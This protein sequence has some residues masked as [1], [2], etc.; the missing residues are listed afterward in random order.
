MWKTVKLGDV[1]EIQ[2]KKAQVKK[3]LADTDTVSFMPMEDLGIDEMYPAANQTKTLAKAYSSYT[4]FE[5]NDVLLAKITPCFENG[6]LGIVS[7]LKNGVG[8]GSSEYIVLRCGEEVLSQYIYYRLS[9]PS[10]RANGKEQMSGAVGHKRLPKDFVENLEIPLPPL[11]EQQ[12]IV[13]KLDAAFAEIDKAVKITVLK[14]E[15]INKFKNSILNTNKEESIFNKA[16][17]TWKELKIG[18]ICDLMTGG[19]PSRKVPEY[20]DNGEIKWLVSGDIHQKEIFD[21]DGRITEEGL[22]NSNAKFLPENSVLIALNG[23]GKTRGTVAIL[24]TKATCNQSLV[25]IFPKSEMNLNTKYLYYVLD[26]MYEKIRRITGDSGN[27]RRGLNMTLINNIEIL[28]PSIKEQENIV[29]KLDIATVELDK[30]NIGLDKILKKYET[31]KSSILK[32]EI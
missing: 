15:E 3:K 17:N 18:D 27:D 26:G 13:T 20:F 1:C 19:T 11:K 22:N 30:L 10:F 9:Q 23:Q 21:C 14:K 2:P 32:H 6:K 8:F 25:S 24:K 16:S 7:N 4:Y 29:Y 31:L 28:L 12:R 5:D